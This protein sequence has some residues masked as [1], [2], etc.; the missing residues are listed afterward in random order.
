[1][2]RL[3]TQIANI[4][5]GK[6]QPAFTPNR[7]MGRKVRVSNASKIIITGNKLEQKK[8]LRHTGYLGHLKSVSLKEMMAKDPR[9]VLRRAVYGM[10]PANKLRNKW[11]KNLLISN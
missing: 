10:L 3:A 11:M 1:M 4:L 5:R 6:D 2:G 7:L 9:E 8:Y